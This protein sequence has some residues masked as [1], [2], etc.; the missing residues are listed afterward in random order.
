MY[1]RQLKE[2][3]IETSLIINGIVS[4]HPKKEEYEIQ[5]QSFEIITKTNDYP[6]SEKEHGP[7]FLIENRHL[8]LRSKKQRAIQRVRNTIINATYDWFANHDF[9]K[10]DAPIF[11]PCLLYTSRCV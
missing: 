2:C 11:T 9:I 8:W 3:G 10:I 7:E 1:K 6:I 4:K 5:T